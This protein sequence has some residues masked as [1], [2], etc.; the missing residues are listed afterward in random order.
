MSYIL[1]L[2]V[3]AEK[4]AKPTF[5]LEER[6]LVSF[7]LWEE[8]YS[9]IQTGP[10]GHSASRLSAAAAEAWCLENMPIPLRAVPE[11]RSFMIRLECSIDEN[12]K[13]NGEENNSRLTLAA[14]IDIFSLKRGEEPLKWE[15]DTGALRLD[16]LKRLNHSQ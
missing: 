1:T 7:D 8:K 4:A 11:R 5:L 10:E 13:G 12:K 14:L 9:V 16:D 15:A 6:F 2:A 3:I